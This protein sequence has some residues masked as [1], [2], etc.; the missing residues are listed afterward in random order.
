M[1]WSDAHECV[2]ERAP[3]AVG[4]GRALGG[5]ASDVGQDLALLLGQKLGD[6]WVVGRCGCGVRAEALLG[7]P[8]VE[9]AGLARQER[10]VEHRFLGHALL[11][12][13]GV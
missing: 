7:E 8:V 12:G 11:V 10:A 4:V 5:L 6:G 9:G 3:L 2:R 13:H 1:S